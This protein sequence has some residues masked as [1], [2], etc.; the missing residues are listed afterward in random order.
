VW[1]TTDGML[2]TTRVSCAVM[3]GISLLVW[4]AYL[5]PAAASPAG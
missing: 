2:V 3:S 1:R 4:V 5:R